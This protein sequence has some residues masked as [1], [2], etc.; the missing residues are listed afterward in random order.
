MSVPMIEKVRVFR[1]GPRLDTVLL[2][3]GNGKEVATLPVT[4]VEFEQR[5]YDP[6]VAKLAVI[7][8][9]VTIEDAPA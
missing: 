3:D 4:G 7:G 9:R 2:Y 8:V 1:D 6:G 5:H